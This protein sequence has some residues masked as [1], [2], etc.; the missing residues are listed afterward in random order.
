MDFW[1]SDRRRLG[2]FAIIKEL[3][4]QSHEVLLV[5]DES[6]EYFIA[7]RLPWALSANLVKRKEFL[8]ELDHLQSFNHPHLVRAHE[9]FPD[10]VDGPFVTMP[11]ALMNLDTRLEQG[12]TLREGMSYLSNTA[13]ALDFLHA[14]DLCHYDVKP[15][16]ILIFGALFET[17]ESG[18][19][20]QPDETGYFARLNDFSLIRS[21]RHEPDNYGDRLYAA[22]EIFEERDVPDELRIRS[23]VLSLAVTATTVLCGTPV[24]I[25]DRENS[26]ASYWQA[27]PDATGEALR[28]ACCRDMSVRPASAG[29]FISSLV[30][31]LAHL[32][33]DSPLPFDS[34][35][36]PKM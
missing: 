13:A 14:Q 34:P 10:H 7:K 9:A 8:A 26:S 20:V 22:P 28:S 24:P 4:L 2:P 1:G 3:S 29:S 32:P 31:S 17:A 15:E 11:C 19:P 36:S 18:V 12:I 5:E 6:G 33:L 25:L 27:L 23:D 21:I 35:L 16:N 30:G